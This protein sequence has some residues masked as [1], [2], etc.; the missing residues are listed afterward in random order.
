[1]SERRT[2][3]HRNPGSTGIVVRYV[4]TVS[5][6][7]G[8]ELRNIIVFVTY[9]LDGYGQIP[10]QF[11]LCIILLSLMIQE[12]H[13]RV[14]LLQHLIFTLATYKRRTEDNTCVR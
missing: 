14:I 1:M 11:Y 9:R 8:F 5:S 4:R 13:F 12:S 2:K 3:S 10:K 6:S 7:D